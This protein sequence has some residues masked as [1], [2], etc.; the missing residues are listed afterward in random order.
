MRR[1]V[2]PS[3]AIPGKWNEFLR[4]DENKKELFV[5]LANAA[6]SIDTDKQVVTT[7][8]NLVLCNHQQDLAG[9]SPCTH[10]EADTRMM[11]H[12]KDA[13]TKGHS[14]V[15]VRTVDTDVVVLAVTSASQLNI[16][17]LWI[18]FGTGKTFRFIAAHTIAEKLGPDCSSALPMFH[19]FTGCDTVSSF[20]GK[21]KK[22]A[23]H[24]WTTFDEVTAA[25]SALASLPAAI[26]E[27]LDP[28]ERFVVLLFDRTSSQTSIDQARKQLF[29][30]KA[31]AI[32]C[33]PPTRA[34][35]IQH[36]KRATY[37]AGHCWSQMLTAIPV[38]P[39]PQHWGWERT[40]NGWAISWT[41]LPEATQICRELLRC[42]CNKGCGARCKCVIKSRT[43]MYC[44]LQV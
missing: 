5:F 38:L 44:P 34:A 7:V 28:L 4:I 41:D 32:D 36:T 1:R 21:G 10:E 35:L 22:T 18:A 27:W 39:S 9:L 42:G 29:C 23:W 2:E 24:T 15:A 33:L 25:F 3:S 31:R 16:A 12:L 17:E 20:A 30:Q 13:V 40:D 11:L 8:N 19:A 37:Q 14:K 6:M 26:E 43:T